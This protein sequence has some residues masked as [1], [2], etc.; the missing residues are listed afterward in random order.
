MGKNR[1][2]GLTEHW[3]EETSMMLNRREFMAGAA[4]SAGVMILPSR[5][6][7]AN[8]RVNLVFVGA[9]GKGRHAIRSLEHN[10][11]VNMVGFADVDD[12]RAAEAYKTHPD[13]PHFKDFRVMLDKLG[14]QVDGVVVSTPDHTHH[15]IA[16][17]CMKAGKHV[18]V[19]KPLAHNVAEVRELMAL[20]KKTGL[21]CQ[22]GNQGHCGGGLTMLDAWVRS[23]FLGTVN[24]V[25]A[26]CN[27]KWSFPDVRPEA[28][29]VPE[30]LDW[31]KW[32]GPAAPVP[33]SRRYCPGSWRGWF[34]FGN[35]ALGDWFCHNA[36][37]PYTALDLDCPRLVEVE[38][39]GPKELSFPESAKLTFTFPATA[40]RGEVRLNWYQG[41]DFPAP[42]PAELE[43]GRQMGNSGGGTLIVGSKASALTGSHAG[44]PR[45]VPKTKMREMAAGRP[46]PDLRRSNCW[47]NWLLSIKG[48]ETCR[49][50]FAYAGRLTETMQFGNIALHVNRNLKIDPETRMVTGDEEAARMISHPAPRE[51]WRI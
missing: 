21:A 16:A 27:A 39:T 25:H 18:Y 35:G 13:V 31:D 47:N 48:E 11:M 19:E 17:C 29:P 12:A 24:D 43:E 10:E 46:K 9:G 34:E 26:W 32:L 40:E 2:S 50:N 37:A 15:Y 4:A 14:K 49:S 45:I 23:G 33:Y 7:G 6:F 3:F 36:D 38:S 42:R 41:K 30:T 1:P 51:A 8:E 28:Q 5:V 44:T 20:E 22:M